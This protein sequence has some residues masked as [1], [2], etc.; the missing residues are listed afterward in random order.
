MFIYSMNG[1]STIFELEPL[2]ARILLSAD[3]AL[4]QPDPNVLINQ[5]I[6]VVD[7]S[8]DSSNIANQKI[9]ISENS[10][11]NNAITTNDIFD[12]LKT[13]TLISDNDVK[14]GVVEKSNN[15][16][17]NTSNTN[18]VSDIKKTE[19]IKKDE[20]ANQTHEK[21]NL[22]IP[23]SKN[24]SSNNVPVPSSDGGDFVSANSSVTNQE[25]ILAS[26]FVANAPRVLWRRVRLILISI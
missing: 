23:E 25:M 6:V 10:I 11:S 5:N 3:A 18:A 19:D 4:L 26:L 24:D 15:T 14:A 2:E 1:Q 21:E 22:L 16:L 8:S 20:L 17:N 13:E 9:N 7:V 12:G